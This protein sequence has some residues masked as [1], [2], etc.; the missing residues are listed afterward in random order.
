MGKLTDIFKSLNITSSNNNKL[1]NLTKPPKR[2]PNNVAPHT[3]ANE[4][5]A[6]EQADLLHLPNDDGY[7]YLLVVTDI[8]TRLTDAEPLKDKTS[9]NVAKALMKIFKRKILK[10][11]NRLEVDAGSEFQGEFKT[12]FKNMFNILVKIAGRHRQ[13][14]VVEHKNYILGTILNKRML[15]EEINNDVESTSW[16]DILP[17][18]IKLVN[19]HFSRK[20]EIIHS[21]DEIKTDKFSED[22][23]PIGTTVRIQLDNPIGYSNESK[24]HGKFRVGDIRWTK[25]T[26][27]ITDFY[28]RP[29]Q[30]VMYQVNDNKKVAYTK[31][32][33]QVV[34]ENEENPNPASQKKYVVEKLL[35]RF[36]KK[37]EIYFLV[38]WKNYDTPT[39]E[40]RKSLMKDI[41]EMIKA[42]ELKS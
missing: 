1:D 38:K 6:T 21:Y 41:P 11:P 30:P 39:E 14:S 31:Y 35:K 20:P 2:E 34:R 7:R 26:Y 15:A 12:A 23:L 33:L 29:Q 25:Q 42:Y 13:Q 22:V 5:F 37:K 19:H 36:K 28:L 18:V 3:T 10:T 17:K 9:K 27:K 4:P 24:L 32:Q 8:A 40:P 16:R